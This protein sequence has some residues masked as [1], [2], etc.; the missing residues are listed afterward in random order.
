MFNTPNLRIKLHLT[1]KLKKGSRN[2]TVRR[3]G[4][5]GRDSCWPDGQLGLQNIEETLA[6]LG[7]IL[8]NCY[9]HK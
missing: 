1:D 3:K 5:S 6:A 9:L 8:V 2:K 7:I 4:M